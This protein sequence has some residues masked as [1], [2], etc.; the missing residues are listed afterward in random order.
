MHMV[1]ET[2]P[3]Y[4]AYTLVRMLIDCLTAETTPT[5]PTALTN[6]LIGG[7]SEVFCVPGQTLPDNPLINCSEKFYRLTG[8]TVSDVLEQDFRFLQGSKTDPNSVRRTQEVVTSG[9]DLMRYYLTTD[10]MAGALRIFLSSH[11]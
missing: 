8:H 4:V 2:L 3:V 9:E 10:E 7:V 6:N 5:T 1:H 11:R